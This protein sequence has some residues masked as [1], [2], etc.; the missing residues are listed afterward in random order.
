MDPMCKEIQKKLVSFIRFK[1]RGDRLNEKRKSDRILSRS[2]GTGMRFRGFYKNKITRC[3]LSKK[4]K[5]FNED[6]AVISEATLVNSSKTLESC[7]VQSRSNNEAEDNLAQNRLD[8]LDEQVN[9]IECQETFIHEEPEES[10][11]AKSDWTRRTNEIYKDWA[12]VKQDFLEPFV[13]SKSFATSWC[14]D[15]QA[16]ILQCYISCDNCRMKRC[17][18]CDQAF[19]K[20]HPFHLRTFYEKEISRIL[21][22]EQFI[23]SG[24]VVACDVPVPCF[25]VMFSCQTRDCLTAFSLAAGKRRVVIITERGIFDLHSCVFQCATCGEKKDANE[26]DYVVSGWWP[27]LARNGSYIYIT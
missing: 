22:P 2:A 4:K 9:L 7:V 24:Q 25:P 8:Y 11:S 14:A 16:P 19:H 13:S 27:T 6:N 17:E 3:S 10:K 12:A 5:T 20:C 1:E 18:K 15:C 23:L 21:L 26:A